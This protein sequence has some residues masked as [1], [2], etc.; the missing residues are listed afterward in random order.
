MCPNAWKMPTPVAAVGRGSRLTVTD[1]PRGRFTKPVIDTGLQSIYNHAICMVLKTLQNI[2]S[3]TICNRVVNTSYPLKGC[4][5]SCKRE[6]NKFQ[7]QARRPI[8]D[9]F[10]SARHSRQP[11]SVHFFLSIKI[12]KWR[13]LSYILNKNVTNVIFLHGL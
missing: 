2:H 7:G 13:D 10:T 8:T 11:I 1:R 5:C 4:I 3:R 12:I 9:V 6:R